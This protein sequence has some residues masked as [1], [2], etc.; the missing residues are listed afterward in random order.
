MYRREFLLAA[1]AAVKAPERLKVTGVQIY[2]IEGVCD[3]KM[4]D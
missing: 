4:M 1:A 2:L 3:M